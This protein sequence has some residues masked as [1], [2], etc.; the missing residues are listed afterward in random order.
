MSK[1][2]QTKV[3]PKTNSIAG[4]SSSSYPTSERAGLALD[5]PTCRQYALRKDQAR[6]FKQQL[7]E[8][9]PCHKKDHTY[10]SLSS[11]DY[12]AAD[13]LCGN[14]VERN[15]GVALLELALLK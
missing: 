9:I 3:E 10:Q 7:V 1:E 11:P 6:E 15:D 13:C 8:S 4:L 12:I 5:F 2:S 14:F